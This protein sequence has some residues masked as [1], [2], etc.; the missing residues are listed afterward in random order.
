[1]KTA[2]IVIVGNE[3]LS[4]K[5]EDENAR[6]LVAEL[7]ALGVSLG[8][9]TVVPDEVEVIAEAVRDLAPRFDYVFTSGGVGPTHDDVTIEGVARGLGRRVVRDAALE[10]LLRSHYGADVPEAALRMADV[11]EGAEQTT[12]D[13]RWPVCIAGNVYVLPGVPEIF[14]RKFAAIRERFRLRPFALR[15]LWV[16]ADESRIAAGL[17]N[18][19][20]EFPHVQIGSY[21]RSD[22]QG[23][24]VRV[25]VEGKD[26]GAVTLA[27]ERLTA[28]LPAG[29]VERVE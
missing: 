5:I 21:P 8:R 16:R 7:R 28:R 25:T 3:I 11:P 12:A 2:A 19:A 1:V 14:R 24:V 26:Q 23:P 17:A 29:S 27:V 22:D 15:S 10:S 20:A 13:L 4:G 9:I 18:V 6:F